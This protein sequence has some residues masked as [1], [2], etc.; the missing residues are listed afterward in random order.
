MIKEQSKNTIQVSVR[1]PKELVKQF[2]RLAFD[3]NL[4]RAWLVNEASRQ[5]LSRKRRLPR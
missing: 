1:M 3:N 5:Y 4:T 2:D